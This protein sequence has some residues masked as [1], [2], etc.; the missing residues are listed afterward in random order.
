MTYR[1]K[2]YSKG[3][4]VTK[5]NTPYAISGNERIIFEVRLTPESDSYIIQKLLTPSDYDTNK[6]YYKLTL[7]DTDTDITPHHYYYGVALRD[8][9]NILHPVAEGRFIVLPSSVR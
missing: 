8:T 7:S 3:L 4:Y 2:Y 6:N 9:N 1:K 5:H